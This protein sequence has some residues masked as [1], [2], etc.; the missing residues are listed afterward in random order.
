MD[1]RQIVAR[2]EWEGRTPTMMNHPNIAGVYDA[3]SDICSAGTLLYELLVG[4]LRVDER[5]Y[6]IAVRDRDDNRNR[7]S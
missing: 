1:G 5:G 4:A 7:T 2:F 3:R 6:R